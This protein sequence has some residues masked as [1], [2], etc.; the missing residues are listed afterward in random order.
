[1]WQL[2]NTGYN[3]LIY[4]LLWCLKTVGSWWHL[5]TKCHDTEYMTECAQTT[6]EWPWCSGT[7]QVDRYLTHDA[8]MK[9]SGLGYSKKH[10]GKGKGW[11]GGGSIN[12]NLWIVWKASADAGVSKW[13]GAT[14]S[15]LLQLFFTIN[16]FT[17]KML[18]KFWESCINIFCC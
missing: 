16:K 14:S 18:L 3:L 5:T 2:R 8:C 9:L 10:T 12:Q 15:C 7:E 17:V 13:G 1:M 4:R 6:L 11:G